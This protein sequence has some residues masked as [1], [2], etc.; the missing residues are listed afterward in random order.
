MADDFWTDAARH[1]QITPRQAVELGDCR[2]AVIVA[3]HQQRHLT[4]LRKL[5]D[6]YRR[7]DVRQL[8][9]VD[10]QD[11]RNALTVDNVGGGQIAQSGLADQQFLKFF[12]VVLDGIRQPIDVAHHVDDVGAYD[13]AMLINV[14]FGDIIRILDDRP[15]ACRKPAIERS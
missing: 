15:G 10:C 7:H 11:G 8:G 9:I 13:L 6:F 5:D 1:V 2:D 14:G 4:R 3:R 12:R